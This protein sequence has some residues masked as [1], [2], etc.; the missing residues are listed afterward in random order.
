MSGAEEL[1]RGRQNSGKFNIAIATGFEHALTFASGLS[2]RLKEG[3][4]DYDLIPDTGKRAQR[5]YGN[6]NTT[7]GAMM[8]WEMQERAEH[9]SGAADGF[10]TYRP[11][12]CIFAQVQLYNE[13]MHRQ[14]R[15]N[16][17]LKVDDIFSNLGMPKDLYGLVIVPR[18]PFR[19]VETR[20]NA[21]VRDRERPADLNRIVEQLVEELYPI[22]RIAHVGGTLDDRIGQ[23]MSHIDSGLRRMHQEDRKGQ[24]KKLK[25]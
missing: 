15:S 11:L 22:S 20:Y 7:L 4:Y 5:R 6:L 16:E 13:Q 8:L 19:D 18:G 24:R 2:A 17:Q 9:R 25:S 3:N 1:L 23:A 10:I 21:P 14:G 12:F